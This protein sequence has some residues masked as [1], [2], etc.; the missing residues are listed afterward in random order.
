MS[1]QQ[2]KPCPGI[3]LVLAS[4]LLLA[5]GDEVGYSGPIPQAPALVSIGTGE[6][7]YRALS[8]GDDVQIVLGP[9]GGFMIALAMHA[10]GVVPGDAIDPTHKYNPRFTFRVAH[11]ET[12]EALGIITQQR[13][14]SEM[15]DSSFELAGTWLVFNPAVENSVYFD[16]EATISLSLVDTLDSN[17]TSQV[18]VTL[19]MPMPTEE[20]TTLLFDLDVEPSPVVG[21]LNHDTE[22][23]AAEVCDSQQELVALS[24]GDRGPGKVA[25]LKRNISH[26]PAGRVVLAEELELLVPTLEH[27]LIASEHFRVVDASQVQEDV[28]GEVVEDGVNPLDQIAL[29]QQEVVPRLDSIAVLA[30]G[31]ATIGISG[32]GRALDIETMPSRAFEG[33]TRALLKD[34]GLITD[35]IRIRIA[36]SGGRQA[37]NEQRRYREKEVQAQTHEI[38]MRSF[39]RNFSN[40]HVHHES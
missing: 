33:I 9:Q 28:A 11:A 14:L 22:H 38:A 13:G 29:T 25:L 7:E 8:D 31:K 12:G 35:G 16:A 20:E 37:K 17:P 10:S 4:L 5:C 18:R 36:T 40:A 27:E 19:V 21:R 15:P 26:L 34:V 32:A 6:S 24:R 2:A 3:L 1:S 39:A 23:V 30:H